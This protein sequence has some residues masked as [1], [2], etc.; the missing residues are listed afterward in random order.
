MQAAYECVSALGELGLVQ[1]EDVSAIFLC[2]FL[3]T[4]YLV[5]FSIEAE[6]YLPVIVLSS[7][8]YL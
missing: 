3:F 8:L 6:R 2:A 1:F 5:K 4:V 7:V